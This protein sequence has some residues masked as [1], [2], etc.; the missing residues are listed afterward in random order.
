MSMI[1]WEKRET[2]PWRVRDYHI[3]I[4]DFNSNLPNYGAL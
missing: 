2:I 3:N 1:L 4:L